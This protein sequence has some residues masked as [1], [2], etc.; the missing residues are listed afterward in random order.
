MKPYAEIIA[1]YPHDDVLALLSEALVFIVL[2]AKKG[3]L[4][5]TVE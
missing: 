1:L 2:D 3:V 4:A 5:H